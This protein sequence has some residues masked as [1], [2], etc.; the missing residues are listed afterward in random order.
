MTDNYYDTFTSSCP[1]GEYA[2]HMNST[3]ELSICPFIRKKDLDLNETIDY[4]QDQN[5][6]IILREKM[7]SFIDSL[8]YDLQGNCKSCDVLNI[9]KGGCL[10][11][12]LQENLDLSSEQPYCMKKILKQVENNNSSDKK[13]RKTMGHW[14]HSSIHHKYKNI[15][16]CIR[17]LPFWMIN[18]HKYKM[19]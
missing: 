10:A 4:D 19:N 11:T 13:F 15:P 1:G 9:C 12:K 6:F 7:N 8:S 14:I 18:F 16:Y 3:G 5:E 17:Q 2:Y